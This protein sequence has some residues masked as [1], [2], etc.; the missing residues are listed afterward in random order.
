MKTIQRLEATSGIA[1]LLSIFAYIYF[2]DYPQFHRIP[3]DES[4][5]YN[6]L[7]AFIFLIA[8]SMLIALGAYLHAAKQRTE[9]FLLVLIFGSILTFLNA[10]ATIIGTGYEGRPFI[11]NLPG[12]FAFLTVILAL[13]NTLFVKQD[14]LP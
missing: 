10:F 5:A 11:G 8:P 12:L 6:W 3:V 7:G 4:R 9:G 13:C 2:I 1:T 14:N